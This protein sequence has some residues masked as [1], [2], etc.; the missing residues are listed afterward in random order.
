MHRKLICAFLLFLLST[1]ACFVWADEAP[2]DA[3]VL[4]VGGTIHDGTGEAPKVG[5]IAIRGDKIVAV[6]EFTTGKV[7]KTI[8]CNGLIVA[9]GF[10][11][12]HNHS[13][14]ELET[15]K[16]ESGETAA[17]RPIFAPET[18]SSACYLTQGC[19]T[20][21]TGNCGG[22]ALDIKN[23]YDELEK[24]PPGINVAQLIPQGSVRAKVIGETR[25]APTDKELEQ[26]LELAR[27]GMLDGAWGMTT[28]L[29][30]VPSA[31]ATTDE[32]AAM[33]K[34]VGQHGGFYASHIRNEGD[35]LLESIEEALAIGRSGNL[36]V[37][38]SHFKASNKPN[39]GKV[40]AGAA[41]IEKAQA[42]GMRVTADQ[43]PYDASSTSIT[44]MLLPDEEREGGDAALIKRLNDPEQVARL[45]PIIEES[46]AKRGRIMVAR[47]PQFPQW[48]GKLIEEI[49]KEENRTDFDVALDI[50]RTGDEAGV[51]FSMDEADVR[52]VMTLPWVATASDGGVKIDDGTRPH[53]RSFGTFPR[54]IGRYAI[55]ENVIPLEQAIRSATGLAAEILGITDR[56]YLRP[57]Q[58]ADVVAFDPQT[59]RDLATFES[60][61]ETSTGVDYLL[62]NGQLAIDDGQ[63]AVTNA[64]RPLRKPQ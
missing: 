26:M 58:Y 7:G 5:D 16:E 63:L 64:G 17:T 30:Y 55:Q 33:A 39:W 29:Q 49:A 12:L 57:G 9:P 50:L 14:F 60:P 20:L 11:D 38:V 45:R 1:S 25:R 61:F 15:E 42:E 2:I 3:D 32:I 53:P 31:Y 4:L 56:G 54:K 6:G 62:V 21:V 34:V 22:G 13:D 24:T 27:Q 52:Y 28:G 47:C 19:T 40:R 18:R 41:L 59:F 37:H 51:S 36:P 46:L 43:Y 35:T 48:I 44:A 8:D 10:I 23:Y